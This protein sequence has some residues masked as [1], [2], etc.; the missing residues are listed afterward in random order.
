M[1]PGASQHSESLGKGERFSKA[2]GHEVAEVEG[3]RQRVWCWESGG[4]HVSEGGWGQCSWRVSQGQG[5]GVHFGCDHMELVGDLDNS[6]LSRVGP[7]RED[8]GKCGK[9]MICAINYV[10]IAWGMVRE[11]RAFSFSS[12]ITVFAFPCGPWPWE[13]A[14]RKRQRLYR[15]EG[16]FGEQ[17]PARASL[18]AEP[19]S[20][21]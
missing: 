14:G 10:L 16:G 17:D 11:I 21:S 3:G 4:G 18:V 2:S 5:R 7:P 8:W 15:M 19:R 6:G 20:S 13:M 1:N 9:Q 12:G